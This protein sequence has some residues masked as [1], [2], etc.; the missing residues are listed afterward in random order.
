[1]NFDI[2]KQ[3][4]FFT[5]ILTNMNA[6]SAVFF[7]LFFIAV[8]F[9][10]S[11]F[12]IFFNRKNVLKIFITNIPAGLSWAVWVGLLIWAFTGKTR[13]PKKSDKNSVEH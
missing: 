5:N 9:L 7:S 13:T 12:A 4:D 10:P 1:M 11:L 3:L 2:S 8:W 6:V